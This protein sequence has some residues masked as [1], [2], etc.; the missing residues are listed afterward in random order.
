MEMGGKST[1]Q[2]ELV[3]LWQAQI[4]SQG[5][6]LHQ[7]RPRIQNKALFCSLVYKAWTLEPDRLI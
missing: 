2:Y 4:R 1:G 5:L 6:G 7:Q 3:P